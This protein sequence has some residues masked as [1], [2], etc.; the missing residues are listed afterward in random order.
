MCEANAYIVD[1]EGNETLILESVDKVIPGTD[2]VFL[3]NIFGEQKIF[4]GKIKELKL[5]DH[6]IV[7]EK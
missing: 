5:V 4:N 1:S 7:L 3:K 2:N 6:K